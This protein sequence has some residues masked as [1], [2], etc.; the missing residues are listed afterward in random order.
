MNFK[1]TVGSLAALLCFSCVGDIGSNE[2][3]GAELEAVVDDDLDSVSSELSS[4][5]PIGSVLSTTAN[6]NLRTGPGTGSS[7]R[8]VIPKGGRVTT[9]NRTTPSGGWYNVKYNG[10]TGWSSG[11]YLKLVSSPSVSITA[12]TRDGAIQRAKSGVGKSYWWGHGRWVPFGGTAGSCAGSCPSCS[13]SGSYGADC[14]GYVAKLWEVPASN[15][16][17]QVD[18]HPYSTASFMGSNSQW[19]TISRSALA[20]ADALVYRK[21]GAGHIVLYESGDG[22]GSFWAYEAKGCSSGIR[23]NLRTAS[24]AYKAIRHY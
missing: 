13:H 9:V 1:V 20:K 24:S 18:S 16:N 19:R 21:D 4:G 23:H 2:T 10:V 6:L 22:W 12:N 8:L 14:S 11:K 15:N 5:V 17:L 7:V 3:E